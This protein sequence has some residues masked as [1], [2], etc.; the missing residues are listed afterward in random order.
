[1]ARLF[2]VWN[3]LTE[4]KN[5]NIFEGWLLAGFSFI[6]RAVRKSQRFVNHLGGVG[7]ADVGV[8]FG[9]GFK[10]FFPDIG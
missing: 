8:A 7:G 6:E 9:L 1:M 5:S 4:D 10:V 3:S 2:Y